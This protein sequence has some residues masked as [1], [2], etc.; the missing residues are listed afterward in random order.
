MT[1]IYL[2]VVN[3]RFA[4]RAL[5]LFRTLAAH[6]PNKRYL[7]YCVDD[8]AAELLEPLSLEQC[9][10]V[11]PRDYETGELRTLKAERAINEYCWTLKPVALEHALAN[12]G[13]TD[14]CVYLDS[15][16]MVFGNPDDGLPRGDSKHVVVT[17]HRPT[18]PYFNQF[19]DSVGIYNAGYVA[20]RN[21]SEGRRALRWWRDR[22]L[23]DCPRIPKHGIYADQRYLNSIPELFDGVVSTAHKGLNAGPWNI[24]NQ[25][26]TGDRHR[27]L[28]GGDELLTYHMQGFR[29][30]GRHLFDLY[31]GPL[32][33]P[34]LIR[35]HIYHPYARVLGR[36]HRELSDAHRSYTQ[37]PD[38][39]LWT[40][41]SLLAE[42]RKVV[43]G[44]TNLVPIV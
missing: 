16:M 9:S 29:I 23:E 37:P 14:W 30:L 10:I 34:H 13:D 39:K 12:C 22:C 15:D 41:P 32:R 21:S 42:V 24:L 38:V 27:I 2:T 40:T 44:T 4:I 36:A 3:G 6:L 28:L 35:K 43:R 5:A 25:P 19:I 31:A 11:R 18:H 20:F 33:M 8:R 1:N 17:P 26:I 7:V